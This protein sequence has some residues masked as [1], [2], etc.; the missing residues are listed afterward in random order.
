MKEII[1]IGIIPFGNT[2]CHCYRWIDKEF[3]HLSLLPQN[4]EITK[5]NLRKFEVIWK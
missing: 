4:L 2:M 3:T 1:F 5:S